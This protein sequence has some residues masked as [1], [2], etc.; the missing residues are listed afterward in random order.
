[1]G[2]WKNYLKNPEHVPTDYVAI[3]R[4]F[5]ELHKY[6][7]LVAYGMF[8]NNTTFLITMSP[9]IK[10]MTVEQLPSSKDK[11]LSKKLKITM[12]LYSRGRMIVQTILMDME[13]DST[14]DELMRKIVDNTSAAKKHSAKI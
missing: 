2:A 7:T 14:K 4:I 9:D 8:V 11:Q 10:F 5:L 13:L 1:M 3:P 6:V 12:K